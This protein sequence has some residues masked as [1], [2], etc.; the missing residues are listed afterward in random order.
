MQFLTHFSKT[1]I[2]ISKYR[3]PFSILKNLNI[4]QKQLK[5]F[6][7]QLKIIFLN[8]KQFFET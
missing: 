2:E 6:F 8:I 4:S 5:L 1:E 7:K 3:I